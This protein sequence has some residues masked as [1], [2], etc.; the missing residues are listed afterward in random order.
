[1]INRL[2]PIAAAIGVAA[3]LVPL[4]ATPAFAHE[5]R[6]FSV[7][8]VEVGFG[9]E[10]P[11]IGDK[12]SVQLLLSS[13]DGKPVTDLGDSLQVEV[14]T[15][16]NPPMKLAMEP[17]FEVGGDGTPG[18]YRAWFFPTE[19]GKYTFHF[20]GTIHGRKVDQSFTSSPTGFDE[21]KDPSGVEYPAKDP[22]SGQVAARLDRETG[23]L[24][25]AAASAHDAAN[26][27]K[28]LA[29]VGIVVGVVGLLAGGAL[30]GLG[31]RRKKA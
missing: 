27:A 20:T 16:G 31:L 11:Y 26:S 21:V 22:T 17:N 24:T 3:L 28:T 18:D 9:D 6:D 23:R 4:A 29:V 13:K 19:P 25:S 12:N 1:M 7:F 2:A 30:G 8:H 14:G 15:G 10:P 5:A